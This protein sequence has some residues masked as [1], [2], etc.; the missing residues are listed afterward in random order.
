MRAHFFMSIVIAAVTLLSGCGDDSPPGTTC[1]AGELCPCTT[2]ADCPD[3]AVEYCEPT[4]LI[5]LPAPDGGSDVADD[6][7]EED[8][9]AADAA[10]DTDDVAE[11]AD[12]AADADDSSTI[13]TADS[14][15]DTADARVDVIEP[16]DAD[17]DV[18][19]VDTDVD[20]AD[21]TSTDAGVVT[22]PD[23]LTE[24][25]VAFVSRRETGVDQLFVVTALDNRLTW[26]NTGD[27]IVRTPTWSPDGRQIAYVTVL[28]GQGPRLRVVDLETGT[29]RT[30]DTEATRVANP[31]W[32]WNGEWIAFEGLS[33][34]EEANDIFIVPADGTAADIAVTDSPDADTS[35]R[36]AADGSLWYISL[37]DGA[38][39]TIFR[40]S[41]IESLDSE[42]VISG[43]DIAGGFALSPRADWISYAR[44]VGDTAELIVYDIAGETA[45][46]VLGT[47]NDGS[48]TIAADGALMAFVTTRN[49]GDPDIV[50]SN[51][52]TGVIARTLAANTAADNSP[53]IGPVEASEVTPFWE[54]V[55][56]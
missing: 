40:V 7:G 49:T 18:D 53:A 2:T 42:D 43:D 8:A 33:A 29:L 50:V 3:P 22:L 12:T 48:P 13:D 28:P 54:P 44:A 4:Q 36:W 41:D 15:T 24:P 9:G 52:A 10:A 30:I 56:E 16:P 1:A 11:D 19:V 38:D 55:E 27:S 17:P 45:V 31:A 23:T 34:G 14:S 26:V 37:N 47:G 35:P 25:W 21:A 6:G 32:S 51:V 46:R 5:C 39:A 20:A